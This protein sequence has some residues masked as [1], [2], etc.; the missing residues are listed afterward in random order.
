MR[1]FAA[2]SAPAGPCKHCGRATVRLL[3]LRSVGRPKEQGDIA[4]FQICDG[5]DR[6]LSAPLGG[7]A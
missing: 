7:V 4:G 5:C 2:K 6:I 3:G 1:W